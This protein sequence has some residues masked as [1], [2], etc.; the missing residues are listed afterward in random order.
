M[1]QLSSPQIPLPV[2]T[3]LP[4]RSINEQRLTTAVEASQV[5][6]WEWDLVNGGGVCNEIQYRI[7]GLPIDF[8]QYGFE[9]WKNLVHPDDFVATY[10]KIQRSIREGN[11]YHAEYR[12]V[13]PDG[14]IRWVEA[15]GNVT[16]DCANHPIRI[17]GMLMDI[18][19]R[20]TLQEGMRRAQEK[21]NFALS[22][23]C[24]VGWEYAPLTDRV[25]QTEGVESI[26]GVRSHSMVDFFKTIHPDDREMVGRV[27]GEFLRE[28]D[29]YELTFRIVRPDTGEVC[30]MENRA[31][32]E[33]D[34][35]GTP[36]RIHGIGIDVTQRKR[37]EEECRNHKQTLQAVI[38]N[39][40]AAV[41]V[42]DREGRFLLTN[43]RIERL[44]QAG[45]GELVGRIDSEELPKEVSD[46]LREND[47]KVFETG[48]A[49]HFEESVPEGGE[50]KTFLCVKFPIHWEGGRP[51]ALGGIATEITEQRRALTDLKR[52]SNE[53][54]R[55]NRDLEQFASVASH[56]LK[57]PLRMVATYLELLERSMKE[58]V[59][60]SEQ[61]FLDFARDGAKRMASLIDSLLKYARLG[62]KELEIQ[63]FDC[64]ALVREV[65]SDLSPIVTESRAKIIID[66]LP[67]LR[68]DRLQMGQVFQNLIS[69]G[70]KFRDI[71]KMASQV[72][73]QC[74]EA[75]FE[76]IF[77][78]SDNG[79]GMRPEFSERI[80][81]IF[82]RLHSR[83]EY[84][85]EGIGLASCKR[86]IERHGGKIWVH[87]QPEEGSTFVFT[88]PKKGPAFRHN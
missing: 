79:I 82:R 46:T 42:K 76:W 47:R 73:I 12:V 29:R 88:I 68:G 14:T 35:H 44:F 57:E 32:A 86:I 23:A 62:S 11:T 70:L 60:A 24:M 8:K 1:N 10:G 41:F 48:K 7:L 39:T 16:R 13:W 58:R 9:V 25:I 59:T 36:L 80:F 15:K 83:S 72:R 18:T 54:H 49:M 45:E 78:V 64:G 85:G 84:P 51:S 69:N 33:R 87:S 22:H 26:L 66:P 71:N 55:S 37:A 20:K 74:D 5:G 21:L 75:Q 2:V 30:W 77:R 27:L 61:Q 38:D 31:S 65:V 19:E 3:T 17:T 34:V 4:A 63:E 53:L 28:G 40:P 6:V 50:L 67:A 52:L 81:E 43:K 56:D